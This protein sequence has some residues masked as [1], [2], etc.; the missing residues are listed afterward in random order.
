MEL[1]NAVCTTTVTLYS[2]LTIDKGRF[3][4]SRYTCSRGASGRGKSVETLDKNKHFLGVSANS[5]LG[6]Q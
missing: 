1:S 3:D 5:L 4:A 2:S 6:A